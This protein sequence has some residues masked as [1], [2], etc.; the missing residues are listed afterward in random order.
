MWRCGSN[1][2]LT[3]EQHVVR[4]LHA[5]VYMKD[6]TPTSKAIAGNRSC[7]GRLPRHIH[8]LLQHLAYVLLLLKQLV[9]TTYFNTLLLA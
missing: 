1:K 9:V 7:D 6:A 2:H 4:A 3:N 5:Y 8:T